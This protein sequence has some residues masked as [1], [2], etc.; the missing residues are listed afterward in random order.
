[1]DSAEVLAHAL[2]PDSH[3]LPPGADPARR[4]TAAECAGIA[5]GSP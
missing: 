4:L 1:M 5:G 3:P 2:H